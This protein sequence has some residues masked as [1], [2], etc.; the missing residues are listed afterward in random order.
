[1]SDYQVKN[2]TLETNRIIGFCLRPEAYIMNS[3]KTGNYS[4]YL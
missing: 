2:L 1:M 4:K 3:G